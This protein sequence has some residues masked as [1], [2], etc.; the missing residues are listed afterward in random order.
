MTEKSF[1]D[2]HMYTLSHP[3]SINESSIKQIEFIPTIKGIPVRKYYL[4]TLNTGGYEEDNVKAENLISFNN[5]KANKVGMPIPQGDI[6][7][8]KVDSEDGSLELIKEESV[9]HSPKNELVK[10]KAG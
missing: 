10:L 3:V 8:L 6:R 7:I 2:Y 1:A 4:I 9:K 5:S